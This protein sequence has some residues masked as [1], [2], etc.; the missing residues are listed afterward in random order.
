MRDRL[1]V[2]WNYYRAKRRQ[3]FRDRGHLED[4]QR[5]RLDRALARAARLFPFYRRF[6]GCPLR[7][8]PITGKQLLID[9]FEEMNSLGISLECAMDLAVRSEQ[10]RDFSP[11]IGDTAVGL[12]SGT[13]G[14]RA[15]F[16][17]RRRE[18]LRWAGTILAKALPGSIWARRRI[19]FLFRA[20]NPLYCAVGSNRIDF[21][22]FDLVRPFD[23]VLKSL[24]EF[25]ADVLVGPS[26]I[27]GQIALARANGDADIAP[28]HVIS[29]AE[30]LEDRDKERIEAAFGIRVHQ[31]YQATEG[32]LATTCPLGTLHLNED[33]LYFERHYLDAEQRRF[34]PIITDF[35]RESQAIIR[36]RLNDV[37]IARDAPCPC[38]SPL[39]PIEKI[40]GRCDDIVFLP[41]AGHPQ[42][43]PVFPDLLRSALAGSRLA[44]DEFQIL[45][46]SRD[47]LVFRY[48]SSEPHFDE[49]ALVA[50]LSR[51]FE[52]LNLCQPS[53]R[54]E[55]G[56]Q[57][58]RSR[59]LRRIERQFAVSE[60][61]T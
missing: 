27:L 34:V 6:Q 51:L 16:L 26:H 53:I 41:A 15:V 60:D 50:C 2:L 57:F 11:M 13:S 54:V 19:A 1:Q 5:H 43:K 31:V 23:E 52:K 38:G 8:F 17:V 29:V 45:Q 61:W 33:L 32:F 39:L 55:R 59:K 20:N 58:E 49:P 35:H 30:V 14:A 37:L 42:L 3:R 12:S 28:R 18:R 25:P 24:A 46:P 48:D 9:H 36:Y 22:F 44:F 21:R 47:Q 40:E 10:S 4:W 7:N 56:T